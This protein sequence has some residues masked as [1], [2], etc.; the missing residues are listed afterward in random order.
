MQRSRTPDRVRSKTVGV[1]AKLRKSGD[2]RAAR[3]RHNDAAS[4]AIVALYSATD[5]EGVFAA[6]RRF[7]RE[8]VTFSFIAFLLR[9]RET[10]HETFLRCAGQPRPPDAELRAI[11]GRPEET[12]KRRGRKLT[13]LT[14]PVDSAMSGRSTSST[15]PR[16]YPALLLG[17]DGCGYAQ[18]SLL[19]ARPG[20]QNEFQSDEREV[21]ERLQV[22]LVTA[23]RG[24]RALQ[25]ERVTRLA[26]QKLLSRFPVGIV[27]LD[28]KER[29]LYRNATAAELCAHW[30]YGG[31]G[32][33]LHAS[34]VFRVPK[35][36]VGACRALD[37][38]TN[39]RELTEVVVT[40]P[41]KPRVRAVVQSARFEVKFL[42]RP[43]YLIHLEQV[44][45]KRGSHA[46]PTRMDLLL[47]LTPRERELAEIVSRGVS[48][49]D[50]ARKLSKSVY[51]VKKQLQGVYRKLGVKTR[52]RL[53]AVLAR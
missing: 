46:G 51:T 23:L 10:E 24:V 21:L 42:G 35:E 53:A 52:A 43:R 26:L 48:N 32:R 17:L 22:H 16:A 3:R 41:R 28:W 20:T 33:S 44:G 39:T 13:H 1:D 7:L 11:L 25:R 5:P 30:N 8:Q 27:L 12:R 47:R 14:L 50:A 31:E 45:G 49:T 34:R 29:T 15:R 18:A 36:V 4:R 6:V 40:S 37:S 2:S 19:V 38:R 9:G